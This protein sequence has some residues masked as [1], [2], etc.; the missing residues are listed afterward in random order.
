[1]RSALLPQGV[2]RGQAFQSVHCPS[3]SSA[4]VPSPISIP[5][6][7]PSTTNHRAANVTGS[8]RYAPGSGSIT[9]RAPCRCATH[10]RTG[11]QN[12]S[13]RP[14]AG[15]PTQE[16][17]K[18]ISGGDRVAVRAWVSSRTAAIHFTGSNP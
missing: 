6:C 7:S 16:C 14:Y 18:R 12:M 3:H 10:C 2:A 8:R 17:N 13:V 9:A 15:S 11:N 1:M 5:A 4:L